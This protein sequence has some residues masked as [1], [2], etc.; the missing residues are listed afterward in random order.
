VKSC[1]IQCSPLASLVCLATLLH[2]PMASAKVTITR[3]NYHGWPNCYVL[4]NGKVEA[5]VVPAISRV[6]Q[7]GFVGE[8]G[9]FWENR[10]LDGR[11]V[12]GDLLVWA[13]KEW[14]NFGGDKAWPAPE[15]DWSAFTGRKGW[16][17]PIAFD[18]WPAD[19]QI[20]G[21]S[22]VLT[23]P[24]DP[25]VGTRAVRK[26][27]LHPRDPVMTITTTFERV[28]G[29]PAALGVWVITQLKEPLGVFAPLTKQSVFTN[30]F[31]LLQQ[32][33]P[34]DLKVED[35]VLSLTR[36]PKSPHKIG[37][38]GDTLVWI[39]EKHA[40]RIDSPR[41]KKGIYPDGGSSTEIYTSPDPLP[42][43]ELETL[44]PLKMLKPGDTTERK[45]I[46]TLRRRAKPSIEAEARD[47]LR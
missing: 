6:M 43:V 25:F 31:M 44:G 30:G 26:V 3:T 7:F 15:G 9:V 11:E 33:P 2:V 35:G 46:Y 4:S 23:T 20:K 36:N 32:Q 45:N 39:G 10:A 42:Y 38:D 8:E 16:R 47:I 17:P 40:L 1:L 37:L 28:E 34:P 14:V 12:N 19:A 13:Q 29:A 18:G 22:L 27:E 5:V 24:N 21:Q 41:V